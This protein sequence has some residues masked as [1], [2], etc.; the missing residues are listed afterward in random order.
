MPNRSPQ[1]MTQDE[2]VQEISKIRDD[3]EASAQRIAELSRT[4]YSHTRRTSSRGDTTYAY[5]TYANSWIRFS[6]AITQGL[7][8]TKVNDR[9][10]E[11]AQKSDEEQAAKRAAAERAQ[12]EAAE[13]KAQE[14]A[15][16]AAEQVRREEEA[17]LRAM[18]PMFGD[19]IEIY[20]EEMVRDASR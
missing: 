20:G 11:R 2:I 19:L 7:N 12:R 4:L 16:K 18:P 9:A 13:Q 3:I 1:T 15:A 6:G 14:A 5:I 17:R 10:L 8:R